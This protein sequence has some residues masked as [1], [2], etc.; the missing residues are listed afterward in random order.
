MS[1]HHT[2]DPICPLC[3][4]KALQAIPEL[5]AWFGR[6]KAKYPNVHISWSYR[7]AANQEKAVI[8]GRSKLHYPNSAHNKVDP[9][10]A[11]AARALDLFLIDDD[12][13]ARFPGLWYAKLNADNVAA[14]EPIFWGGQWK[15]FGDLDHFEY[16][17]HLGVSC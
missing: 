17:D 13:A 12:G 15:K 16:R 2:H 4:E 14:H 10:G 5:A 3:T 8:E 9:K 1:A 6:V 7:D 11:P